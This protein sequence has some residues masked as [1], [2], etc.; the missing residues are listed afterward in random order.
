V[1]NYRVLAKPLTQLLKHKIFSWPPEDDT[2]F[3]TL[4]QTMCSV[5]VLALPD[6]DVPF[7]IETDVCEIGVGA[8]LSQNGH[9][10]AFFSKALSIRNQQLSTYEKEFLAVLMDVDKW[11]PYLLKQ[12]FVIR[13]DHKSLCYLQDQILSTDTQ[14]KAMSKLA[15][16]NFKL[17]Y[18]RGPENFAANALLRVG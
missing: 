4:K 18:K 6:F 13:T 7:K 15:G 10:I 8:V 3:Q 12:P 14:Q 5:P 9:P 16:L 1:K 2:A 17:Q 11:R